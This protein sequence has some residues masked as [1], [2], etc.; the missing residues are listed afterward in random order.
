MD[1]SIETAIKN[2][3][4]LKSGVGDIEETNCI[5]HKTSKNIITKSKH[6]GSCRHDLSHKA[7]TLG[8]YKVK[9][10]INGVVELWLKKV[11]C[12]RFVKTWTESEFLE[13]V[14]LAKQRKTWPKVK[15]YDLTQEMENRLM[16]GCS[17]N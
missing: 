14:E 5:T 1:I 7:F 15:V 16:G 3:L 9:L 12:F 4:F 8:N 13:L 2:Y 11:K 17:R 6:G 10:F